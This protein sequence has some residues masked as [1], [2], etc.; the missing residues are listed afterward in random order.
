MTRFSELKKILKTHNL[1]VTNGRIDVL[2]FFTRKNTTLTLKDLQEELKD[3]DRVTLYRILSAFTEHGIIHKI[4][5]AQGIQTYGLCHETCNA[6]DHKH[7]H[8]HF[9]CSECGIIECLKENFPQ[10]KIPGYHVLEA[11]VM[12]KGLCKSCAA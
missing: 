8:M 9:K 10:V 3:S 6:Y 11:D 2:E 12:L 4:P 5:N 1:R 7:D